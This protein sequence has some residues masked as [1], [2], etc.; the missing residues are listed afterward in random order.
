MNQDYNPKEKVCYDSEYARIVNF[1][2]DTIL[3]LITL[4]RIKGQ[5]EIVSSN[6]DARKPLHFYCILKTKKPIINVSQDYWTLLLKKYLSVLLGF[7]M[8]LRTINAMPTM[9]S[10]HTLT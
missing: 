7:M 5:K 1:F 10:T 9:A 6:Q 3:F 8:K 4:L 2:L